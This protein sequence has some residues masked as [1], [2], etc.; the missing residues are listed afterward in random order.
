M[1]KQRRHT[2]SRANLVASLWGRIARERS[3]DEDWKRLYWQSHPLTLRHINRALSGDEKVGWIE[4]FQSRFCAERLGRALSLGCGGGA[5][6][7]EAI[8]RNLC[9]RIDAVDVAAEAL[10]AARKH[11]KQEGI[12]SRINYR[13]ADLEDLHLDENVYDVVLASHVL[14]HIQHLE[15]LLDELRRALRAGGYMLVA[16]YI[17]PARLQWDDKQ[18]KLMN[19]LLACFPESMRVCARSGCV[20]EKIARPSVEEVM[21]HDPSEA[22]RPGDIPR[23]LSERFKIIYRAD[24]GGTLLMTVLNELAQHFHESDPKDVALIDMMSLFERTLIEEGVIKSDFV[25][26]I[27]QK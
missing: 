1:S 18:E 21:S 9:D 22:V 4:F 11:A 6:E 8:E 7:R 10:E 14:H 16:D 15:A 2:D 3:S 5:A 13:Q 26:F 27:V 19:G 12:D 17:G 20:R 23:L 24:L 25:F